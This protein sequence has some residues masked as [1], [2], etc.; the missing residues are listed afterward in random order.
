MGLLAISADEAKEPDEFCDRIGKALHDAPP[1]GLSE[2]LE[3]AP[4]NAT[5]TALDHVELVRVKRADFLAMLREF[6]AVLRALVYLAKKRFD[7]ER[8][9]DPL[10]AQFVEQGLYQG[11]SLLVLDLDRCT[12]CDECTRACVQQHGTE[13]HGLPITRLVRDGLQFDR[14]LIATACRSCKDAYCMV[15][16]PVDAIHRGRHQQIV[17]EDH[18]IG[19][20]LCE[21][22]CPYGNIQTPVSAVD[23]LMVPDP[24]HLGRTRAVARAKAA[25]CDLCDAGGTRESPL[26]RCVYACPHDAAHRTTGTALLDQVLA[27][28]S[29]GTT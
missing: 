1:D 16:C 13:S 11:Q 8:S 12:R 27:R 10:Y 18:C 5:C 3:A 4:R 25:T 15:G 24:D 28:R 23:E 17:I 21:R 9:S 19:C 20:G 26:P 6:P 7:E 29:S 14:F 22:N 2:A